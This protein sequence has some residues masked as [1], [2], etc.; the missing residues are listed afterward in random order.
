MR[1]RP[2]NTTPLRGEHGF[3]MIFA[4]MTLLVCGLLVAAAIAASRE[5]VQLTHTY[6]NQQ[7]AYFAALAGLNAYKYQLNANPDYWSTCPTASNVEVPGNSS[8]KYSYETLPTQAH[9]EKHEACKAETSAIVE[10]SGS[11]AGT[12]RVKATGT[13]ENSRCGSEAGKAVLCKRSIIATFEHSS[14]LNYAFESNYELVDPATLKLTA[15]QT[16]ECE[17]YYKEGRPNPPC[18]TFPWIE[19]DSIEGPFH[20]NDSA[21]IEAVSKGPTFGRKGSTDKVEMRGGHFGTTPTIYGTYIENGPIVYPPESG[22][23]LIKEAELKYEGRTVIKLENGAFMKVKKAG[24]SSYETVEY[25]KS[26][27]I[28]IENKSGCNEEYTPFFPNYS[29]TATTCGNAYVSG[30]YNRSLTIISEDNIVING[31]ITT[32]GGASGGEPTGTATLG[33]I[34]E[35]YVRLYHP[36]T[37]NCESGLTTECKSADVGNAQYSCNQKSQK[38]EKA[39]AVTEELGAALYEPVIDAAILSSKN[40]WGVDNFGCP[41]TSSGSPELGTIHIWGSIAEEWRG[42]VTCCAAGGVY[43]K[44]YKWDTRLEDDPPPSFLSP[45]ITTWTVERQTAPPET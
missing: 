36:V 35:K 8:E 43:L 22:S 19:G 44:S 4:L 45:K 20:T 6:S 37:G 32:T 5:D 28:A 3:A 38:N 21:E 24:A 29:A 13:I 42:R 1:S 41:E 2:A 27:V 33:L 14:F 26:G 40:S 34:A 18:E 30:E 7:N 12:F 17:K 23:E 25:P 31:N 10:S 15:T 16:K 11:A 39:T 9:E